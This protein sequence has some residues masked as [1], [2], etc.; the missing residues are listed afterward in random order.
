MYNCALL[1]E[2][3][4][5]DVDC[6]LWAEIVFGRQVYRDVA[7]GTLIASSIYRGCMGLFSIGALNI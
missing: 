2:P 3:V 6:A 1:V 7:T 5:D 4:F